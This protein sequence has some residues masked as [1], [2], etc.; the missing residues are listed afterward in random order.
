[1]EST[2]IEIYTTKPF[3]RNAGK[4]WSEEELAGFKRHLAANPEEGADLGHGLYKIR[5]RV[6]GSGKRGGARV[7]YYFA[8]GEGVIVLLTVYKKADKEDL[9]KKQYKEL[10][11]LSALIMEEILKD[12]ENGR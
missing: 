6:Q 7:I 11:D 10:A 3:E 12:K 1:M 4:I 9:T 8:G 2:E 5:Y